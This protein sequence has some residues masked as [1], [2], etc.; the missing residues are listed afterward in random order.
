MKQLSQVID[1]IIRIEAGYVDHPDDRGG[2]T[3]FGVTEKVARAYGYTGPMQD[4]PEPLARKILT[5]LYWFKPGFD[6]VA[7]HSVPVAIELCDTGVNMGQPTAIK[8]LQRCLNALNQRGEHWSDVSVDGQI[9]SATID[10][11]AR[12]MARRGP[13][14]ETVLLKA[15][16]CLQCARYIEIAE[17]NPSQEAFVYGWISNRVGL[18]P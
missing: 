10:A 17:K 9:G 8:M 2:P 14:G 15:L 5:D 6:K 11:L 7:V 18:N 16:N 3:R 4:L 1:E 13:Q 12:F